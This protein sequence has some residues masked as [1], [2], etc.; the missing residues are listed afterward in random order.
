M[1]RIKISNT[2]RR[3]NLMCRY[4]GVRCLK[5]STFLSASHYKGSL[6]LCNKCIGDFFLEFELRLKEHNLYNNV[7]MG[8]VIK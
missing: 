2:G 8:A 1:K 4:C 5:D 7:I 3:A 6:I